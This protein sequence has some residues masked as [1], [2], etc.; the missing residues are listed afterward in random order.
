VNS[1]KAPA[2]AVAATPVVPISWGELFDKIT[3]LEIKEGHLTAERALANVRKEL[4]LLRHFSDSVVH[5]DLA[6]L[7][8]DLKAI[9]SA[10]WQLEDDIRDKE[11]EKDFAEEF[12]TMARSI[13]RENDRR[14]AMKR[15][16][17]ALLGSELNEEKSYKAY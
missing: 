1:E 11:R 8:A 3:I 6:D 17:N 15:R 12:I 13:Y 5:D 4:E 9:N 10:L 2:E 16:I 7:V 14:A